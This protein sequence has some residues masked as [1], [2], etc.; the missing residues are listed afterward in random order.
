MDVCGFLLECLVK[1]FVEVEV[2]VLAE[3]PIRK[4][5]HE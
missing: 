2:D 1:V 5:I 3:L 4:R